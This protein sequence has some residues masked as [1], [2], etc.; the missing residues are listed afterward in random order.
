MIFGMP[1][2]SATC[3]FCWLTVPK[4]LIRQFLPAIWQKMFYCVQAKLE[5]WGFKNY[6]VSLILNTFDFCNMEWHGM[7]WSASKGNT[8]S[9]HQGSCLSAILCY[10]LILCKATTQ[11]MASVFANMF[12]EHAGK[13][14]VDTASPPVLTPVLPGLY[15]AEFRLCCAFFMY[16]CST[17][18]TLTENTDCQELTSI[19]W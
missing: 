14:N 11:V 7:A 4:K 13:L 9:F 15:F 1:R 12:S 2:P 18:M 17:S 8:E 10:L 5:P 16:F 3:Q 6:L 19:F